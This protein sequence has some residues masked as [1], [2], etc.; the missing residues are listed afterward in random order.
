MKQAGQ[1]VDSLQGDDLNSVKKQLKQQILRG[2]ELEEQ[3]VDAKMNWATLD[4]ENDEL[5]LKLN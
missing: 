1:T 2:N 5:C 3:L 4:M